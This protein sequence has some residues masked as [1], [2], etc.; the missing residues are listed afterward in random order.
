MD[1]CVNPDKPDNEVLLA[2]LTEELFRFEGG[3]RFICGYLENQVASLI[4]KV[5]FRAINQCS[6][7]DRDL[8]AETIRN[9]YTLNFKF[10]VF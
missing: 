3:V 1:K 9:I 2:Q 4:S 8:I 5:H 6:V 10:Y 7:L